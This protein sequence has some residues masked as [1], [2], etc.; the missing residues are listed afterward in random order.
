MEAQIAK[1]KIANDVRMTRLDFIMAIGA[2]QVRCAGSVHFATS[3]LYAV[4]RQKA[5]CLERTKLLAR[6]DRT[7]TGP[8][9][10]DGSRLVHPGRV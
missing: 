5:D 9:S 4:F 2:E 7:H 3:S 1:A 8:G 10:I 6:G